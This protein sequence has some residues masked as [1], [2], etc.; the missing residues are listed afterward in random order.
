MS[1]LLQS[2]QHP[3]ADQLSAF[4][5]HALPAHEREETLAHLATCSHCRSIVALSMPPAEGLP[6]APPESV[7]RPWLSGWM[8]V[9]PAGVALAALI[10]AGIYIRNGFVVEKHVT[11]VQTAQSTPPAPHRQLLPTP[12]LKLQAPG[13]VTPR[14]GPVQAAPAPETAPA[15]QALDR[16][17]PARGGG[18][19][20]RH[21][22]QNQ[23][24]A[25]DGSAV[26]GRT[27]TQ[28][29]TVSVAAANQAI[30]TASPA[31]GILAVDQAQAVPVRH[32]LPSGLPALSTVANARR[33][34]AIDT[35]NTLF[36]SN[37]AGDHW[38]VITQPW[39]GRA[40]KVEL[41]PASYQ[42]ST[43]NGRVPA[44]GLVGGSGIRVSAE[45]STATL[46]GEI[47]DPAGA[48]IPNVSVAVTN[49]LT[50]VVHKTTTD[51]AGRYAVDQLEPG[52]Y[53]LEAEAP[54]FTPREVSGLSLNAAQQSQKD[55]TLAVGASAQTVEV[56]G[57][58][59]PALAAPKA[60]EKIAATQAAA[61]PFPRFE[62]TTDAGEHWIST[63]GR[64]WQREDE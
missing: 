15:L 62:I 45:G 12:S 52:T 61:P 6:E 54:G 41:V 60:K 34:V 35:H 13:K 24:P 2:G 17:M 47:T 3:D 59:Q 5:E 29:S 11:P 21:L 28:S 30:Q 7:R 16:L 64:S 39:Q 8:M 25:F 55:L 57:A 48:S 9:W 42:A 31:V 53:T 19:S 63:D 23:M 38:N 22:N 4:M 50:Q 43:R 51:P 46:S 18:G 44:A 10:L 36:S 58:A 40:V 20:T 14:S 27:A 26:A 33:V 56:Q 32:G 49:S 37:D 1:D